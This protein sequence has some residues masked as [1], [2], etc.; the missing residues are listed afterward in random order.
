M[1]NALDVRA[2]E[3]L[4]YRLPVEQLIREQAR[5]K[6]RA[7]HQ[8]YTDDEYG[9]IDRA[10]RFLR[11]FMELQVGQ[12]VAIL[13]NVASLRGVRSLPH[14][15]RELN[16]CG[17]RHQWVVNSLCIDGPM[18]VMNEAALEAYVRAQCPLAL[19]D[20]L[21]VLQ[22]RGWRLVRDDTWRLVE[23][24]AVMVASRRIFA[25]RGA[26]YFL[27][28]PT[29]YLLEQGFV[30]DHDKLE[31]I[32]HGWSPIDGDGLWDLDDATVAAPALG[33]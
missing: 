17:I 9:W 6:R 27:L 20:F 3:G 21:R 22:D 13:Q 24:N 26:Y 23:Q 14:L 33:A 2:H 19:T 18:L 12:D 1:E 25:Q 10:L 29:P 4:T 32:V 16:A 11:P 30:E 15:T 8:L 31:T 7:L 5:A 28:L